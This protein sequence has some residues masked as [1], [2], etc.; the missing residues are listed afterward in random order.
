[1]RQSNFMSDVV[2]LLKNKV[3][4]IAI[5]IIVRFRLVD[6]INTEDLIKSAAN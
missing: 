2:F 3:Q 6:F 1:M 5:K 4:I